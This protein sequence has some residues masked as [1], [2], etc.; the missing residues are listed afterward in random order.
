MQFKRKNKGSKRTTVFKQLITNIVYPLVIALIVL[1]YF[2]YNRTHTLLV[3]AYQEKNINIQNEIRN[4]LEFQ[5]VTLSFIEKDMDRYLKTLSNILVSDFF[6]DIDTIENLPLE[7][8]RKNMGMKQDIYIINRQGVIVNTTFIRDLNL[9]LFNIDEKHKQ[10][11]LDIFEGNRFVSEKL[12][13]ERNTKKLKKYT[14]QP[15]LD[16]KYIIELGSYSNEANRIVKTYRSHLENLSDVSKGIVE[17]DLFL[18]RDDPVSFINDEAII[19]TEHRDIYQM[20]YDSKETQSI[21]VDIDGKKLEYQYIYMN[22]GNTDLYE[23]SIIRIV[24]D[25]S[26]EAR[27]I[28]WEMMKLIAIFSLTIFV[29]FVLIYKRAKLITRPILKLETSAIRIKRGD[30]S[31]R[32]EVEGNNELTVLAKQFNAMLSRIAKHYEELERKVEERTAEVVAQKEEIERQKKSLT[33]SIHYA[34]RIQTAILPSEYQM[35]K[36]LN[37]HFVY[38]RPKDIVSGDFYWMSEKDGKVLVAAADCTGHGVP[39]AFMSMIGASLLNKIVNENEITKPSDVLNGLR[40]GVVTSLNKEGSEDQT[41]DG[42]DMSLLA[43]DFAK[44]KLEYSGAYNPLYI[45]RDGELLATKAD[46]QPVG[47]FGKAAKD[48]T[49]HEV[50]LKKGDMVYICSDGYQDQFGGENKSKFMTAN[51]KKLLVEI[52]K[53]P[54]NEQIEILDE[55]HLNWRNGI[56]QI[57][58]IL[59]IGIEI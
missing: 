22:R 43:I 2:N 35:K 52:H 24:N 34:R 23:G 48:F 5:D 31:T 36:A 6:N 41:N 44:S 25:R 33:D 8:I 26:Y 11:L 37:K 3:D 19:P 14:Y 4:V 46:R 57:D 55:R 39:G 10:F 58:D 12:S 56:S 59:I 21:D 18:G 32:A 47:N 50:D 53:R 7:A 9:N 29:L 27:I 45:I 38:Y 49:N 54:M 1:G 20:T 13:L 16:G 30:F 17:V 15:T 51:F 28:F 40:Q 42:M